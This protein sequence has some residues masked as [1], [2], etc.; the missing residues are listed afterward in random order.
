M[1]M[2]RTRHSGESR[3][4]D[5]VKQNAGKTA[6]NISTARSGFRVKPGMTMFVTFLVRVQLA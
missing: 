5:A 6:A 4:P 3:N 1:K 2:N